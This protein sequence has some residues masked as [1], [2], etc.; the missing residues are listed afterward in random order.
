MN[1]LFLSEIFPFP[2]NGGEKLR[3]F[4]LL[5][6]MSELNLKVHAVTGN[7]PRNEPEQKLFPGILFYPYD[8]AKNKKLERVSR[9]RHLF[10]HENDLVTLIN[11][12]LHEH[13]IDI[14]FID[15]HFYGQ[16]INIFRKKNIP[17]IYG[18]HN[19]QAE[20]IN[21][22][23]AIS[24]KNSISRFLDY[25]VNRL[26]ESFYFRKADALIVVSESDKKYHAKFIKENKIFV[27]PNFLIESMYSSYIGEKENYILMT[28]N[29]RAFQNAYGLEWFIRDVWD[30]E[31]SDKAK[32][33]LVGLGSKEIY[34]K[35]AGKYMFSNIQPVGEVEELKPYIAKA[36][37]SIVPLLHGSGSRLKCLEA[38]ALK[39]QLVSTSK[40][41]EGIEHNNSI[42]L[43]DSPQNFKNAILDVID[44]NKDYTEKAYQA[45]RTRYSLE[46]NKSIFE[47]IINNLV[48]NN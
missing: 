4:G 35:L 20:L 30:Q 45:F 9:Y 15:Y 42:I 34:N 8:F 18:T 13:S 29:F 10:S 2:P 23:P 48:K 5:R 39:T 21:Q 25:R 16:Y 33:L 12:I 32:L 26:H 44:G 14:A 46:P 36:I 6:M 31:L 41:S 7:V 27:I 17:V 24:F 28:A 38:M 40:G 22:Q 1:L 11:N 43:A 19:A 37:V 3:S 47:G